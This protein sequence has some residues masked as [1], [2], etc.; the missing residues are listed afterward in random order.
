MIYHSLCTLLIQIDGGRAPTLPRDLLGRDK[1]TPGLRTPRTPIT[2]VIYS[3]LSIQEDAVLQRW[4][5]SQGL[6]WASLCFAMSHTGQSTIR[7]TS[8]CEASTRSVSSTFLSKSLRF[9]K[10]YADKFILGCVS[11]T[12]IYSSNAFHSLH[13]SCACRAFCFSNAGWRYHCIR[14]MC[15]SEIGLLLLD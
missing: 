8:W 3:R 1:S 10:C 7:R 5:M 15:R 6:G 14:L 13:S 2:S 12:Y 11:R 9:D 4:A